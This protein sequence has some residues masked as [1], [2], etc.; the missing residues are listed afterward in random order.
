MF[1]EGGFERYHA[2]TWHAAPKCVRFVFLHFLSQISQRNLCG[3]ETISE[4]ENFSF[5]EK[6]QMTFILYPSILE[7]QGAT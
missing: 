1:V 2:I 5:Q 4:L 7:L 6:Y 3:R